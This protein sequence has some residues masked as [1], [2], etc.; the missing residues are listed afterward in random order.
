M[1]DKVWTEEELKAA[2]EALDGKEPQAALKWVVENFD[3]NDFALACSFS[4]V[5]LLDMLIKI[6]PDARV[7]F[8]DT[9]FLFKETC[10]TVGRIEKKYGIRVERVSTELAPGE[11]DRLKSAELWRH[12]PDRC[13]ELL[14]VEPMRR[15]LRGL[16]AWITGIRRDQAPTRANTPVVAL[17]RKFG[18][19]KV[20]PLVNWSRKDIWDYILKNEVPYNALLDSGYSSIG[21]THCTRPVGPGGDVRS[22]R[23]AGHEKTE[24]GLHKED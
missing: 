14:K 17:D 21:C 2:S 7:F 10:E 20:C 5:V 1:K 9:G 18:L 3:V 22:G 8:I 16:K 24:C 23:W 15:Y 13:C 4:E 11:F 6:R 19:V 12:D